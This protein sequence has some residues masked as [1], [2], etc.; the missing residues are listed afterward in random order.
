MKTLLTLLIVLASTMP[1][2]AAPGDPVALRGTLV[3]PPTLQAE[4]FV[5]VQ[6]EDGRL[7][8]ADLSGVKR[9]SGALSAGTRV[10]ALGVEGNRPHEVTAV[11][12]GPGETAL[13]TPPVA[14]PPEPSASPPTGPPAAGT[15]PAAAP[16]PGRESA[17][18]QRIDG[19]VDSISGR[20]LVLRTGGGERVSVDLSRVTPDLLSVLKRNEPVTVLS[21]VEDQHLVAV[22]FIHS[23][24]PPAA[25]GQR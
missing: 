25:P 5:V 13:A 15:T 11:A 12:F 9:P 18:L 21:M 16:P 6:T 20:T 8:Y 4:P 2:L 19:R 24:P 22:G 23:Q 7:V 17:P 10:S 14:S 3:W 1:A